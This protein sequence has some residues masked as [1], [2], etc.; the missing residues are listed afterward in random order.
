MKNWGLLLIKG[1]IFIL[2]FCLIDFVIGRLFIFAK[3]KGMERHPGDVWLKT[4]Y[5]VE[6]VQAECIII[7][8]STAVHHYIPEEIEKKTGLST[9]NCG[10]DGCFFLYSCCLVNTILERYT[11]KVIIMDISPRSLLD[12]DKGDEYQ[13]MRYL[14]YYYDNDTVVYN[15]INGKSE[16]NKLLYHLNGYRFNSHFV[17]AFY[18]IFQGSETQKGYIPLNSKQGTLISKN[19]VVWEGD[20]VDTE[21]AELYQTI[22]NC[23]AKEVELIIVTSPYYADYD[24]SVIKKCDEFASILDNNNIKYINLLYEEPFIS[25]ASLYRDAS[26]LNTDGA[27]VMTDTLISVINSVLTNVFVQENK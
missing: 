14:S 3:D 23:K 21:L 25:D 6:K 9:Y 1:I 27:V 26:H 13:N 4:S 5:S 15:Y 24:M 18:P 20:W 10:Q 17:Y 8:S 16:K 7:G 22:N 2:L 12:T 11:P 19:Q